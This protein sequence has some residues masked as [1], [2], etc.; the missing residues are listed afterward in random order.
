MDKLAPIVLFAYNRPEHTKKTLEYLKKNTLARESDL[1]IF[2]DGPKDYNSGKKVD[3]VKK[4]IGNIN[5]FKRIVI[6]ISKENKGLA[7]SV[8]S[9]VSKVINDYGKVIVLEDDLLT[10]IDFLDYMNN[11]LNFYKNNN[12]IWS[13]SGYNIP[14]EIPK[15]Y[16]SDIY[17]SYRASSWG[18]A[19]WKDRWNKTDWEVKSYKNFYKNKKEQKLFDKGGYDLSEML[20]NQMNGKIDS[21]AIR[22]CYSQFK[23]KTFT[24]YPI[25]TKIKNIGLDGSGTHSKEIKDFN[26]KFNQGFK[27]ISNEIKFEKNIEINYEILENFKNFYKRS[28]IKRVIVNILKYFNIYYLIRKHI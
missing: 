9:G 26:S 5:G 6:E 15:G 16:K 3:E 18:Y 4:I 8:I 28:L 7:N 10:S 25:K 24:I 12:K 11:A 20:V 27:V 14:I 23:N 21:W 2:L 1:F 13:I 17:L 19:T 22:W